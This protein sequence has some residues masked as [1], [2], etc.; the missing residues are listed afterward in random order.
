MGVVLD[1]EPDWAVVASLIEQAYRLVAQ[2]RLVAQMP[3]RDLKTR[4]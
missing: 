3:E 1:D 4:T 2:R